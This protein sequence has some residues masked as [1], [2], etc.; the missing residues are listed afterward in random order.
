VSA[1]D[2]GVNDDAT[3]AR[4]NVQWDALSLAAAAVGT[5]FF[6]VLFV[7][8]AAGGFHP[9]RP[10][11]P[12]GRVAFVAFGV[13]FGVVGA[14]L[15]RA[16]ARAWRVRVV[17]TRDGVTLHNVT[18]SK[19]VPLNEI[20]GFE[21]GP[22]PSPLL[23]NVVLRLTPGPHGIPRSIGATAVSARRSK[24]NP[25]LAQRDRDQVQPI[26]DAM[27]AELD[28]RRGGTVTTAEY[29]KAAH[30]AFKAIPY[31]D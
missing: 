30:P 10:I 9:E 22:V 7:V 16:A 17:I 26:I 14:G 21:F 3:F 6:A 8:A 5:V 28:R 11:T 2:Q 4:P 24:N 12:G 27:N 20:A 13:V 29:L 23:C 15:A 18:S 25:A 31:D 19:T 1:D